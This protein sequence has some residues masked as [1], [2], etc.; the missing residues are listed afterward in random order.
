M[1]DGK[2]VRSDAPMGWRLAGARAV[3]RPRRVMDF[4][5]RGLVD[6]R[7]RPQGWAGRLTRPVLGMTST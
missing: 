2:V 7:G 3:G 5:A 6:R 1:T 4:D